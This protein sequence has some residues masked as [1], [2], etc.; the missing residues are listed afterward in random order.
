MFI[1]FETY[2]HCIG[3]SEEGP[4][5]VFADMEL[6]D[7]GEEKIVAFQIMDIYDFKPDE[8]D[9]Y[10]YKLTPEQKDMVRKAYLRAIN[11]DNAGGGNQ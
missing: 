2:E 5:E 4:D 1:V 6:L 9:Q 8:I 7:Q 10:D 3:I 11:K